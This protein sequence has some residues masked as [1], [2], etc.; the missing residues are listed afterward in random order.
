MKKLPFRLDI[1]GEES[2]AESGV[3]YRRKRRCGYFSKY[4]WKVRKVAR[5]SKPPFQT[6]RLV[7]GLCS[8]RHRAKNTSGYSLGNSGIVSGLPL[9]PCAGC[10]KSAATV[11][12]EGVGARDTC[13]CGPK[14]TL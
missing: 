13:R 5:A 7:G 1:P 6:S 9:R 11:S 8:F 2:T 12:C 4:F 10:G 3:I 14:V